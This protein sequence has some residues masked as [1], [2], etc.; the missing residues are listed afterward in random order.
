MYFKCAIEFICYRPPLQAEELIKQEMMK[1]LH[2]DAVYN[3]TLAQQG[4]AASKK[5]AKPSQRAVV[6][7]A[8]H[9]AYL[10]QHPLLPSDPER[11]EKVWMARVMSG[12]VSVL[13]WRC[14]F[15]LYTCDGSNTL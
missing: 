14:L 11:I 10:E 13:I 7:K 2:N 12:A 4:L 9:L 15:C 1:M 8:A 6:T 5:G 3:P